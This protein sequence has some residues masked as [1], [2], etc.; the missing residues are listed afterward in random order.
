MEVKIQTSE[1]TVELQS[2]SESDPFGLGFAYELAAPEEAEA[3]YEA[4]AANLIRMDAAEA[5]DADKAAQDTDAAE[6]SGTEE[7]TAE[8]QLSAPTAVSSSTADTASSVS[9]TTVKR[10]PFIPSVNG[11]YVF[12]STNTSGDP[13][14]Y[15][16]I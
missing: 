4:A 11:T 9:G 14:G 13:Y 16:Y 5:K 8:L 6:L 1:D 15:L 7:D 2:G 12:E 3:W 10:I